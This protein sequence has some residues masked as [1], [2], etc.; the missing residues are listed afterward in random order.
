MKGI[1]VRPEEHGVRATLFDLEA[2]IMETVW[3]SGWSWFAVTEVRDALLATRDIAYTTVMTTVAR[4][5]DKGVLQ[6]RRD[7]RRYLYRAKL[8]RASFAQAV[9]SEVL[10]SLDHGGRDAAIALL[11]DRV[12]RADEGE[13]ERIQELIAVRR[14]E[15]KGV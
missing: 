13:L 14:Q 10:E 4:L 3:S 2:D 11:V 6:R 15:L 9:A 12:A 8:D 5:H 1:R 7:G